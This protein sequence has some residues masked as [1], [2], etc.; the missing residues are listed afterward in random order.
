MSHNRL[1]PQTP[2][3]MSRKINSVLELQWVNSGNTNFDAIKFNTNNSRIEIVCGKCYN[4]I[5]CCPINTEQ[6]LVPFGEQQ[7]SLVI[8]TQYWFLMLHISSW[9]SIDDIMASIKF[10]LHTPGYII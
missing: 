4:V 1:Y 9:L 3:W 2:E 7:K 8:P 5:C 10:H 6:V